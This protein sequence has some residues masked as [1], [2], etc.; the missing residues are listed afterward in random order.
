MKRAGVQVGEQWLSG[1]VCYGIPVGTSEYV[2]HQLCDKVQEVRSEV[3]RVKDVLGEGDGQAIWSIL[4]CSI[5][6]KLDW[7][8]SLC[9]PSDISE[10][11]GEL[12]R[13]LWDLLEYATKL[14]IPRGRR[15]WGWSV[16]YMFL[17]FPSSKGKVSSAP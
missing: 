10:A 12:D 14:H 5:A 2:K 11:A 13:V 8:L 17:V 1:F 15:G 3:D 4:K 6:Q 9:Y 16:C 7:H